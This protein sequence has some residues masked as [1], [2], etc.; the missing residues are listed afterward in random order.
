MAAC[1]LEL[2][3]FV[4]DFAEEP[5]VLYREGRLRRERLKKIDDFGGKA[6]CLLPPDRQGADDSL[7][8]EEWNR[9]NRS[10]SKPRENGSDP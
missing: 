1:D 9:Q 4:L 3:A 10:I 7:F 5:S 8:A 6:A 2:P